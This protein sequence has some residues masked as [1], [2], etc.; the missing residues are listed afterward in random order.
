MI[1]LSVAEGRSGGGYNVAINS[2]VIGAH[3]WTL[4]SLSSWIAFPSV[5]CSNESKFVMTRVFLIVVHAMIAEWHPM[6][7]WF[8]GALLHNFIGLAKGSLRVFCLRCLGLDVVV[9]YTGTLCFDY[10]VVF[11]AMELLLRKRKARCRLEL[12][13]RQSGLSQSGH[14]LVAGRANAK[15]LVSEHLGV[16]GW[17]GAA[18]HC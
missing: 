2:Y 16:L 18:L 15:Q 5:F 9:T 11:D 3:P 6:L 4:A 14:P 1:L 17:H 13:L 12:S 8:Q 7:I 10:F